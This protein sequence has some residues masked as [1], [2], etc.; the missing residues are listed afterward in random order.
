MV[1]SSRIREKH[2]L[3]LLITIHKPKFYIYAQPYT[4]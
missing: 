3:Y 1:S 4:N 2:A